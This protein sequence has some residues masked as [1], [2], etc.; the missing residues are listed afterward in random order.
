MWGKYLTSFLASKV[1]DGTSRQK[2]SI[3]DSTSQGQ[4]KAEVEDKT[5]CLEIGRGSF[6]ISSDTS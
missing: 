5:L 4:N 2:H 3:V 6:V 1:H